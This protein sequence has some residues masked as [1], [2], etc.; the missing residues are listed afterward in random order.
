MCTC[1]LA[2]TPE[3]T[4]LLQDW[5]KYFPISLALVNLFEGA[6]WKVLQKKTPGIIVMVFLLSPWR[7]EL[8]LSSGREK[9][10]RR[11]RPVNKLCLSTVV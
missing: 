3:G 4:E 6:G 8:G 2:L 11:V 7:S 1:I 5:N 9:R 10:L